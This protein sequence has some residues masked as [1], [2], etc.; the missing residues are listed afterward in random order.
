MKKLTTYN[1]IGLYNLINQYYIGNDMTN[2]D[3]VYVLGL[4]INKYKKIK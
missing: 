4:L 3:M 1:Q 2:E